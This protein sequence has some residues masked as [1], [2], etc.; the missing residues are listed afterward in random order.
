M[1]HFPRHRTNWAR[2]PIQKRMSKF[3]ISRTPKFGVF[4]DFDIPM[5]RTLVNLA[6]SRSRDLEFGE[7]PVVFLLG[8]PRALSWVA[9]KS[10]H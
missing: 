2:L 7:M 1:Y 6:F 5:A 10:Y 8:A 3:E 9:F 4:R